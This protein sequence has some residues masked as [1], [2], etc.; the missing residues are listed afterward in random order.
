MRQ[1]RVSSLLPA[2]YRDELER[3]VFFN[4][5]QG[6]VTAPLV[7]SVRRYGVPSIVEEEDRLRFRVSAFGL[8]PDSLC[9][10]R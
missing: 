5:K 7:E 2:S 9:F 10:R 6:L 8:A 1:I 4:P 3:I